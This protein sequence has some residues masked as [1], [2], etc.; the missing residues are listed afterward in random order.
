MPKKSSMDEAFPEWQ[1]EFVADGEADDCIEIRRHIEYLELDCSPATLLDG[2]TQLLAAVL[3]Y[4][5][6]DGREWADFLKRQRYRL[7]GAN[8][9]Y[10]CLTFS[11]GRGHYGRVL[12]DKAIA[13]VDFADLFGHPW[14]EYK[15]AGFH[16]V[17]ISKL[18]GE[19]I[20]NDELETLYLRVTR[21]MYYDYTEED[22][23]VD[24]SMTELDDTA[25]F[26]AVEHMP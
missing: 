10:Y 18:D 5:Q 2:T 3:A 4:L 21:D 26:T 8:L 19:P 25:L 24:V 1:R 22:V 12:T 11:F 14:N 9:P 20:D 23:G 6:I 17:Y 13:G 15:L 16:E 7:G